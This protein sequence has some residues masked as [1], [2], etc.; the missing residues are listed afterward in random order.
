MSRIEDRL[1][2]DLVARPGAG[3][4][5]SARQPLPVR[6]RS[7]RTALA[8][9]GLALTGLIIAVALATG[10]TETTPAYAVTVNANGSVS[11]TLNEVLGVS[12]ANEQL[13]RLGVRARI[14]RVEAGCTQAAEN[15]IPPGDISH[16]QLP[17]MVEPQKAGEG[18]AG[19]DWVIHPDAI[20]Q[21]DTVLITAQLANEGRPVATYQGKPVSAVGS[22]V[23]LYRGAAPTCRPPGTFYPG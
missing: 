1:W 5:L 13:T 11:V 19:L 2:T 22:S 17:T 10:G 14:A 12:G 20:P 9:T 21:G 4:A 23:S 15:A 6:G 16:E 8:A 3:S 18:L 7:R